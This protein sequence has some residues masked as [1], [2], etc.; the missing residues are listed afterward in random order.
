[1]LAS[2]V[3]IRTLHIT[4]LRTA[5]NDLRVQRG[6]SAFPWQTSVTG[7]I[8][9]DPIIEMRSALDEALGQPSPAY[10]PGLAQGQPILAVHIQEL[11]NRVVAN[12]NS[13]VQIPSDGHASLSYDPATNRINSAGFAYDAAGNQVRALIAGGASQRFQYD[14]ANRLVNVK[15]DNNQTVIAS[16]TYG[17][18]N[19]RLIAEEGGVRTTTLATA[20]WSTW[21]VAAPPRRNGRR[22]TSTSA[23]GCFQL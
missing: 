12:W 7:L 4:E 19:E 18:S 21:R 16:Y 9:A 5:I 3:L 10:S 6:Y 23:P 1:L 2:G 22:L 20:L 11:R 14:A 15:T 13:S 17:D 8:K